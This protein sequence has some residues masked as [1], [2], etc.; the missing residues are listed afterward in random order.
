MDDNMKTTQWKLHLI[1]SD[2]SL[3][4]CAL[5][6]DSQ[7]VIIIFISAEVIAAIM[8]L[9]RVT[10]IMKT[11]NFWEFFFTSF[12]SLAYLKFK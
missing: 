12:E 5:T 7:A 6:V 8:K 2:D 9:Y 1:Y 4:S 10:F 11:G 3:C